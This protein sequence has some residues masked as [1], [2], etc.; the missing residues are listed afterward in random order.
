MRA[1]GL[2]T[3]A[4]ETAAELARI[5][6]R[7][8]P[9]PAGERLF[10]VTGEINATQARIQYSSACHALLASPANRDESETFGICARYF[11]HRRFAEHITLITAWRFSTVTTLSPRP[12]AGSAGSPDRMPLAPGA[13]AALEVQARYRYRKFKPPFFLPRAISPNPRAI[14]R[15]CV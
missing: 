6:S 15:T 3:S 5:A 11:Y 2:P 7:G 12:K 13:G 8:F 4:K 1:V 14:K 10:L 9:Q